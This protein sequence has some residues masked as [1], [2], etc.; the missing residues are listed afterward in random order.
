PG[1]L[2]GLSGVIFVPDKAMG[3]RRSNPKAYVAWGGGID[4]KSS[5]AFGEIVRLSKFW[6][7]IRCAE[8]TKPKSILLTTLVGHHTPI[9]TASGPEAFV[10]MLGSLSTELAQFGSVP[11]VPNPSLP[12]EN[13]A[14][15]WSFEAFTVF[16][17]H[18]RAL[19]KK[20]R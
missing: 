17:T 12:E 19:E 4:E 15:D 16:E 3:W 10:V 20:A 7:D 14:R 5:G 1:Y 13:L 8:A 2:A 11:T 6:R 18:I 9:N